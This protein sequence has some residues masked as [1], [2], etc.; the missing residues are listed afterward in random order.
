MRSRIAKVITY[1]MYSVHMPIILYISDVM[2]RANACEDHE[3]G[4]YTDIIL[5]KYKHDLIHSD[6]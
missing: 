3:T 4:N 1:S 6:I 2:S 5:Y